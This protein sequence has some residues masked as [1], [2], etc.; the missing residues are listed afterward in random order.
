MV[1]IVV[2]RYSIVVFMLSGIQITIFNKFFEIIN[3][4]K[5]MFVYRIYFLISIKLFYYF[6]LFILDT[7]IGICKKFTKP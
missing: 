4:T 3:K 2:E 7:I 5:N 1:I 6:Q